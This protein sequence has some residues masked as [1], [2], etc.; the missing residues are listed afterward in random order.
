MDAKDLGVQ[1]KNPGWSGVTRYVRIVE[2]A[3]SSPVT[4]PL[5]VLLER[6]RQV[7]ASCLD[8]RAS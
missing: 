8:W 7:V 1:E 4:S 2:V 6:A 5:W 3:G